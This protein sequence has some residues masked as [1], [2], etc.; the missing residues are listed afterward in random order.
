MLNKAFPKWNKWIPKSKLPIWMSSNAEKSIESEVWSRVR[1]NKKKSRKKW[2]K[3]NKHNE[4]AMKEKRG[5]VRDK[6]N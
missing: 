5:D 2:Q 3:N 4:R 6:R 1:E